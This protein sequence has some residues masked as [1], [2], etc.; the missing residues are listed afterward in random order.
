MGDTKLMSQIV[1]GTSLSTIRTAINES[2]KPLKIKKRA[3]ESYVQRY[4]DRNF[5]MDVLQHMELDSYFELLRKNDPDGAYV[6]EWEDAE[7]VED[8][9]NPNRVKRLKFIYV[10]PSFAKEYWKHD[11]SYTATIDAAHQRRDVGGVGI[12]L[13]ALN[14]AR[15]LQIL[16]FAWARTEDS[17]AYCHIF[18]RVADDFQDLQAVVTDRDK[19]I[20]SDEVRAIFEPQGWAYCFCRNHFAKNMD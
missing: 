19:G 6:V 18:N 17:D 2:M 5:M 10:V 3:F 20:F 13:T 9:P 16:C 7:C 12:Y 1:R 11:H 15:H 14:S 8:F 4:L